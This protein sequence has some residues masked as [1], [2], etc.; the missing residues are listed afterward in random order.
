MV[1]D[2]A[3][4]DEAIITAVQQRELELEQQFAGDVK[5]VKLK[6]QLSQFARMNELDEALIALW[7]EIEHYPTRS[8]EVDFDN[9]NKLNLIGIGG[10]SEGDTNS[11]EFIRGTQ[12]FKVTERTRSVM[13]GLNV[14]L[15]FFEDGDEVFAIEC[16]V[17]SGDEGAGHICQRISTF[18]KRGNWPKVLLEYYGQIKTEKGKSLNAVKYFCAAETKSHFEV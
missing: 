12:R 4:I 18:K 13:Q 2:K 3:H 16:L 5:H 11:V 14:D 15:L 7:E 17:N 6:E 10:S 1:S 9:W 8:S